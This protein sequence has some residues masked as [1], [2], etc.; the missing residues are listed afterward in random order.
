MNENYGKK[1]LFD[2]VNDFDVAMLVTHTANLMH[3]RPMALLR[4]TAHEG[5]FWNNA[6]MQGLK[7][8]D[9]AAKAYVTGETPEADVAQHDKVRL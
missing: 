3:A 2:V 7:Y 5:E 9:E 1:N 4:F 8:A 6:G